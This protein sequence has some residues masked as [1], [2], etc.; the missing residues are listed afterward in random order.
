M[1]IVRGIK[2]GQC[3]WP[4][5]VTG[6][7][8]PLPTRMENSTGEVIMDTI[9][10]YKAYRKAQVKLHSKI[11]NKLV[12]GDDF[13]K[14]GDILGILKKDKVIFQHPSE[15]DILLDFIIYEKIRNGESTLSEYIK[16][17]GAEN[18]IEKELLTAMKLSETSLYEVI[19]VD[20]ENSTVNLKNIFGDRGYIKLMDIAF[21]S[22]LSKNIIIFSRI[23]NLDSFNMTSGLALTFPGNYRDFL[24]RK[25]KKLIKK[26][27]TGVSS[28]DKF[29]AFFNLNRSDG[30]PVLLENVE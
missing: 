20:K 25:A 15:K 16:K 13:K 5:K 26:G 3:L 6:G 28:I 10:K 29:I 12:S 19:D 27:K 11:L 24:I 23:L 1:T 9:N 2:N 22:S 21:S 18:K 14:A 30:I 4:N 17:Y 8:Y 7:H